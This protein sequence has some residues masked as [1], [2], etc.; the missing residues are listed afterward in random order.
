MTHH[1]GNKFIDRHSS[2]IYGRIDKTADR[3]CPLFV[4]AI[5]SHHHADNGTRCRTIAIGIEAALY[6]ETNCF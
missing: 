1:H 4:N 2:V 5:A 3:I 6:G